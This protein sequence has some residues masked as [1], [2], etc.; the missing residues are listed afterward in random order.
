[1]TGPTG[2]YVPDFVRVKGATT[3]P[4]SART[5]TCQ[6]K[7]AATPAPKE[8]RMRLPW[9]KEY[10]TCMPPD[11]VRTLRVVSSAQGFCCPR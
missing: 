2:R 10:H 7:A 3:Y 1:M 6:A 9:G 11:A 8:D 5:S 4:F